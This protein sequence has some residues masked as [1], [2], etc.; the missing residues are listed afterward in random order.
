VILKSEKE[1]LDILGPTPPPAQ[2]AAYV[3]QIPPTLLTEPSPEKLNL[4]N[5]EEKRLYNI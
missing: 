1:G 3:P 4:M 5:E 2:E